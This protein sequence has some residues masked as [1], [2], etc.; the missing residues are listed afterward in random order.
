MNNILL[1]NIYNYDA[2]TILSMLPDNSVDAVVTDPP[3]LYD[4]KSNYSGVAADIQTYQNIEFMSDGIDMKILDECIR[5]MKKINIVLFCSREQLPVYY[6]Y[7]ADKHCES[8]FMTWCK[9]N[10]VPAC[11]GKYLSDTEYI[12][13]FYESGTICN[14]MTDHY[15]MPAKRHAKND[16]LYHPTKK[17]TEIL[18][19]LIN[20]TTQEGDIVFDP[21]MGSGS[22]AVACI[23]TG[24]YFIGSELSAEYHSICE[25]R[26]A[27][28]L[29]DNPEYS[30]SPAPIM[31]DT[32][33]KVYSASTLDTIPERSIDMAY[34]DITCKNDIPIGLF[35]RLAGKL[36]VKPHFYIHVTQEQLPQVL[37]HFEAQNYKYDIISNWASN[38]TTFL[39]YLKKGGVQLYGD[40]NSKRKYYEDTRDMSI[41]CQDSISYGLMRRIIE[42]STLPGQT[43]FCTGGFGTSIEAC[44]RE[45][46]RFIA[47]EED[48]EKTL[49]CIDRI[50]AVRKELLTAA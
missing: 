35:D 23:E 14:F 47:Y 19:D 7:F 29:N 24:R 17:P 40:Y 28:A 42:N 31:A 43:V 12:L 2:L 18:R 32:N 26:I 38:G 9:T 1:N 36:M 25:Q 15:L 34:I 27:M 16:P 45:N 11:C 6:R 41:P 20:S 13:H 22:T 5:V 30:L 46:R 3:Y 44:M 33:E 4:K 48:T 10:P 37:L 49:P 50:D 39:L 8:R 21:F